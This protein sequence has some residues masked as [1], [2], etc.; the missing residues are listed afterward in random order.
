[1]KLL[2]SQAGEC[3]VYGIILLFVITGFYEILQ[4]VTN[5]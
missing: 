3:F 2:L 4:T 1:M 5:I